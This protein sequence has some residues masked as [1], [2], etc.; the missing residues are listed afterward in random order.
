MKTSV[1]ML[2]TG[3]LLASPAMAASPYMQPDDSW[4]SISGTVQSVE[5]DR[6]T[7]DYGEG[8][9]VVEMDDG[10]RDAD[11][12]KLVKGDKVNVSGMIDDDFFETTTIEAGSVYVENIGTYFYASPVDEEGGI[13]TFV[14]VATPVEVSGTVLQGT[15]TDVE[16]NQ[17]TVNHD[18]RKITVR[19]GDMAYDPLDE[20]GYQRI[21]VGDV[22][23]VG[24]EMRGDFFEGRELYAETVVV[25]DGGES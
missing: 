24:G 19:T 11:A 16:N 6:F 22:V 18:L 3:V 7:L 10:D 1:S 2:A 25:I 9:V 15:V 23:T 12:Y 4:I 13:D 14:T 20:E 17:F 21:E 8:Q 5:A